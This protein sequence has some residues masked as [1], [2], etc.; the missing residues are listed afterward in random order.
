MGDRGH[1]RLIVRGDGRILFDAA[2]SGRDPPQPL[3]INIEGVRRL[4]ILVDYGEDL[5]VA[6]HLDLANARIS[7]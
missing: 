4:T 5:D 1:V 2:L 6:D 3:Q 7:K